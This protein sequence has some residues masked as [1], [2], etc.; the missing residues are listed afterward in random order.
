MFEELGLIG[1][2]LVLAASLVILDR[3]SE[4]TIDN[5]VKVSEISGFG[6]TVIGFILVALVTTL[7]ELS[8]SV[9]A[10]LIGEGIGLAV[11]NILGSNVV[12]I[13]LI[14]GAGFLIASMKSSDLLK[15]TPLFVKEE[16]GT[17]YFGIFVASI[18][19]LTLLY[20]GHTS[21]FIG[22]I[23][24]GIFVFYIFKLARVKRTKNEAFREGNSK[25]KVY[26]FLAVLGALIVVASAN[27]IVESAVYIAEKLGVHQVALGA[28]IVAF[29]TS[30]PEFA[31][32]IKSAMK[33][34]LE[35]ALG[36]IVGSCFTN[37]T[38]ILGV[39]LVGASFTVNIAAFTNLVVFSLMANLMLWYFLSSEKIS[40]REATVLL[41]MYC[42]FLVVSFGGY[43]T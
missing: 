36:N 19:P 23:L 35:L 21:R 11:G 17:L 8:V 4:L 38:L 6:K 25:L 41:F 29:G 3:A 14:L 32:T 24:I 10:A 30:V 5:A 9:F 26:V 40:W 7:P 31:N 16:V 39:A 18:V 20:I 27:F 43:K 28:T 22:L 1:N 33:G 2:V 37:T 42:V 13:C 12:N 15:M 34:H